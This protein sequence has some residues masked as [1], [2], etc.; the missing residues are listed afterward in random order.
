MI[1]N[2]NEQYGNQNISFFQQISWYV[3]NYYNLFAG[4]LF[5]VHLSLKY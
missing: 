4:N 3:L 1:Y 2:Q 5:D